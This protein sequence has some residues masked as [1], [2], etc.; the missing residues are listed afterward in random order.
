MRITAAP[1]N[2]NLAHQVQ[3]RIAALLCVLF[4]SVFGSLIWLQGRM[5]VQPVARR[6]QQ[7]QCKGKE[8]VLSLLQTAVS[9][10]IDPTK[11]QVPSLFTAVRNQKSRK[12]SKQKHRRN[13]KLPPLVYN[14]TTC[15]LTD[16]CPQFPKW[17]Q[18]VQAY[19]KDPV[20]LGMETC[21]S[22]RKLLQS[23]KNGVTRPNATVRVAG[24]YNSGTNALAAA[25]QDNL[26][27]LNSA[28][29]GA[30]MDWD[31][32]WGKHVPLNYRQQKISPGASTTSTT[33]IEQ[34]LPIV[35]VRD[36][37]RW[38]QAMVR[39]RVRGFISVV[40]GWTDAS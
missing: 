17:K 3:R 27:H 6:I 10:S 15:E 33:A 24:L 13:K 26:P 35:V 14:Q 12:T 23:K 7:Q 39:S 29:A 16:L 1:N 11:C 19:G 9:H 21:P 5:S 37:F 8:H 28:A 40:L 34:I 20:I 2:S 22:Y 4:A 25:L 36:P 18:V 31:V 38:M 30:S 32:P